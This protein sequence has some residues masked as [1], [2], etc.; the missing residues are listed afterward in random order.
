MNTG[1]L[2]NSLL[3]IIAF[4][5]IANGE[6]FSQARNITDETE[7]VF[8]HWQ[9]S[10]G[11]L[12]RKLGLSKDDF[13][14]FLRFN[15]S[16]LD[17]DRITFMW[18]IIEGKI[19]TSNVD[20]YMAAQ[21]SQ[22]FYLYK[23]FEEIKK[24]YP[25]TVAEFSSNGIRKPLNTCNP[26]C[27]NIDFENGTLSGWNAYYAQNNSGASS[28][29]FSGNTGGPCGSV[30]GAAN[31]PNT[32]FGG[33]NDYQVEIMTGGN[34]PLVPSVPR[35]S[36][37]G[38]KY[39]VRVGDSTNP[40]QGMAILNQSF[41]VTAANTDFTYQYAVFLENPNHPYYEQ[42]FFNVALLDQNGDTI[43]HC[44]SYNVVSQ[45]GI[46]GFKSVYYKP[47]HDSV[48]YKNW[49]VVF[50]S[51]K[52]YIGQCV[53]IQFKSSDCALGGHFG[54]AYVDA[55]CSS[56]GLITSSPA[57]CGQKYI[58]LTA[59]PGGA[60]YSWTGPTNGIVSADTTQTIKIDSSGTYQVIVTPVTGKFCADT[61]TIN[62]PKAPGPPPVP[63]FSADTVCAGSS[64]TFTNLSNPGPGS[65]VSFYW[66]FYN[67]GTTNDSTASPTWTYNTAGTYTVKLTE[68]NNGCGSDTL[69]KVLVDPASSVSFTYKNG[70]CSPTVAFTNTSNG[71][72]PY[73]WNFGDG[74]TS[75]SVS[76]SHT[77]PSA[78]TYTVTLK[79]LGA[80]KCGNDSVSEIITVTS[81][82]SPLTVTGNAGP[83]CPG[84]SDVL[85]VTPSSGIDTS[86][87]W[88]TGVTTY[89][90]FLPFITSSTYTVNPT[91]TTTYTVTGYSFLGGCGG[92]GTF[93]VTVSQGLND[94]IVTKPDTI[95]SGQTDTL[96]VA[97]GGGTSYAWNTGATTDTIT[98]SP[99]V[100]T[101]YSVS[102]GGGSCPTNLTAKVIVL[103]GN[104]PSLTLSRDTLCPGDTATLRASGGS[105]Y[106][107]S[108]TATTSSIIVGP[109]KTT[110]YS[111]TVHSACRSDTTLIKVVHIVNY[112][113]PQIL[114]ADT[115]CAGNTDLLIGKGGIKITKYSWSTGATTDS[116]TVSPAVTTTYK[117]TESNGAC[118]ASVQKKVTVLSNPPRSI[119]P[120]SDSICTG[121]SVMLSATGGG[122]YLWSTS[123]T[124][125]SITVSPTNTTTY[126]VTVHSQCHPDT[127]MSVVISVFT[128]PVPTITAPDTICSGNSDVLHAGGGTVGITQYLWSTSGT[129]DS[130][131]VSPLTTTTY[132]VTE[133]NG[134]CFAS[135]TKVVTVIT[136][137]TPAIILFHDSICPGVVDSVQASGGGKYTWSTGATTSTITVN[138]SITTTY[139][140]IVHSYC[141]G[142]TP[143][144][145]TLHVVPL[146]VPSIS[147]NSPICAGTP[148]VLT[149]DGGT[150]G[151]KYLWST[152]AS[153]SNIT[154]SPKN[155][156][157]YTITE[158]N[159]TCT[160]TAKDT[161]F[162][163]PEPNVVIT[164]NTSTCSNEPLT[165][166]ATGGTSY[167]WNTVPQ[168]TGSTI[169][170]QPTS[171]GTIWVVTTG[172]SG[173][174][175][176]TPISISVTTAQLVT[177]C[178]DTSI[179]LG[180]SVHIVGSG[181]SS[182]EWN[183]AGS[184]GCFTCPNTVATPTATT[185]YTVTGVDA[186][187]CVSTATVVISIECQDFEVPNVFTPNNDKIN[188]LFVIHAEHE[189]DYT[190]EIYNRWGVKV[191]TSND[192][193]DYWNGKI[194]NTGADASDG[195]YY[196]IIKS[197]C[198]SEDYNKHGFVE[199]IRK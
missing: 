167:I 99:T 23:Q 174:A 58:N 102:V 145:V 50:A 93:T 141:T 154:V 196:Y 91:V 24:E 64:T 82:G 143:L 111:V 137:T 20:G 108:T 52:A 187:G 158:S 130:I 140:V 74:T 49:T 105:S 165:L 14:T 37:F 133:T 86:F 78:N 9:K 113:N 138:P 21:E 89:P 198:G 59:P 115:I 45:S 6:V 68:V 107:W 5:F 103:G 56:L 151:T 36:P 121:G 39:S 149:A 54:Y 7:P 150:S 4:I 161:I 119:S 170:F 94:S 77:Y 75:S 41:M 180:S 83:I 194:N 162:M 134:K 1:I 189:P 32:N 46:N 186:N 125:D 60:S 124:T 29:S 181:V 19:T 171:S 132:T 2:K 106:T 188:D 87:V 123:A 3:A 100:T 191:F 84:A 95:C 13:Q 110:T 112:P 67:L 104:S 16:R 33:G 175:D 8:A 183:P 96:I 114:G 118:S 126:S 61:L 155:Q 34:D 152:G 17:S 69:I 190:I 44:G 76:P 163:K 131:K 48:Y 142:N 135:T 153:T 179:E 38:G 51:L 79:G 160:A 31:D 184:V 195:V 70:G 122:T 90:T 185:T 25:S 117:L 42:P 12:K 146:P 197:S 144:S 11:H 129:A 10:F 101:T 85:T 173:C 109:A 177:A 62:V 18:K 88:S 35:V 147:G 81:G 164:G 168:Q 65:G 182:Y 98:V 26:G 28:F 127:T 40:N 73:V 55:S 136:N 176:T 92:Q 169:T 120:H 172:S 43:P 30:T 128:T 53:T 159:G 148:D 57:L 80:T 22:Y 157:I 27:T 166:T 72:S 116:I 139:S 192:P 66:D 199:I 63:F 15:K 97:G 47:D 178:C 156:T 71:G 193:T